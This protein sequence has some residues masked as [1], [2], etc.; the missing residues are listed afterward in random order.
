M[1][2]QFNFLENCEEPKYISLINH[3]DKWLF[4]YYF[5]ITVSTTDNKF[6]LYNYSDNKL[7]FVNHVGTYWIEISIEQSERECYSCGHYP[8]N[9][10]I[11]TFKNN[12]DIQYNEAIGYKDMKGNS[13]VYKYEEIIMEE[14]LED[15]VYYGKCNHIDINKSI[16]LSF[17][18][19]VKNYNFNK[20]NESPSYSDIIKY[21]GLDYRIS[22][23]FNGHLK[24]L[25]PACKSD[26]NFMSIEP[27][28]QKRHEEKI[29]FN[30]FNDSINKLE[31]IKNGK[32]LADSARMEGLIDE[33]KKYMKLTAKSMIEYIKNLTIDNPIILNDDSKKYVGDWMK[34]EDNLISMDLKSDNKLFFLQ[35]RMG[36]GKSIIIDNILDEINKEGINQDTRYILI[37][38]P[39]VSFSLSLVD[40]YKEKVIFDHYKDNN[41]SQNFKFLIIQYESLHKL[42]YLDYKYIIIDEGYQ[43]CNNI[44]NE[45]TSKGSNNDITDKIQNNLQVLLTNCNKV[46]YLDNNVSRF[47]VNLIKKLSHYN[48]A[49]VFYI[50]SNEKK[51]KL[52][53]H[54]TLKS[55]MEEMDEKLKQGKRICLVMNS[56]KDILAI[57][58][59][60]GE[61]NPEV[62]YCDNN[63]EFFS[64]FENINKYFES[65]SH[66]KI[67]AYTN[68]IS[69]GIDINV[70]HVFDYVFVIAKLEY[71][72]A[73]DTLQSCFRVRNPNYNEMHFYAKQKKCSY[74]CL[75][76]DYI[77]SFMRLVYKD[78]LNYDEYKNE[79]IIQSY[80]PT[81]FNNIYNSIG[82]LSYDKITGKLQYNNLSAEFYNKMY[83]IK[84]NTNIY[85][86]YGRFILI[87]M[88]KEMGYDI[89]CKGLL[90]PFDFRR[91]DME[92]I[93]EKTRKEEQVKSENY[94]EHSVNENN[95]ILKNYYDMIEL[96]EHRNVMLYSYNYFN[97]TNET[98]LTKEIY[99]EFINIINKSKILGDNEFYSYVAD[100]QNTNVKSAKKT[101]EDII[102]K[103]KT[104]LQYFDGIETEGVRCMNEF[105]KFV[106][107]NVDKNKFI[108]GNNDVAKDAKKLMSEYK[109]ADKTMK[110]SLNEIAV[111]ARLENDKEVLEKCVKMIC[112]KNNYNTKSNNNQ[113]SIN[114]DAYDIINYY[115]NCMIDNEHM[116]KYEG[117]YVDYNT[118]DEDL[119]DFIR[120]CCVKLCGVPFDKKNRGARLGVYQEGS[121]CLMDINITDPTG[122]LVFTT[123]EKTQKNECIKR[124]ARIAASSSNYQEFQ[125]D[126]HLLM[127]D[128]RI[129]YEEKL[130][131]LKGLNKSAKTDK[132]IKLYQNKLNIHDLHQYDHEFIV[133]IISWVNKEILKKCNF[134]IK[135]EVKDSEG[136]KRKF[137][138]DKSKGD[139]IFRLT[140]PKLGNSI[141][142]VNKN[143]L[144]L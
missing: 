50:K 136:K 29:L 14:D 77:L 7:C 76:E 85:N 82:N 48:K 39:R 65:N 120:Y 135:T 132:L 42:K 90:L 28:D 22:K 25:N 80:T 92:F 75:F 54:D 103:Y 66:I 27:V 78:K 21:N 104:K 89:V 107:E 8:M 83:H 2:Y 13:N 81:Q 96:I 138:H 45:L 105:K 57:K 123:A 144:I 122:L 5:K 35:S 36:S 60:Y 67:F 141:I 32:N 31:Q 62:V 143:K 6:V 101:A 44:S 70:K 40:K 140:K 95:K 34:E 23:E 117:I 88:Y 53:V 56:V 16:P 119:F 99:E 1:D 37:I 71:G 33:Q 131:E 52:I 100:K 108:V 93:F 118:V 3:M 139:L 79:G 129:K 51:G 126:M 84:Y 15:T 43:L 49:N 142:H 74:N 91:D 106:D 115:N 17:D 114:K 112:S 69:V 64:K 110:I 121:E 98:E 4:E 87:H 113:I 47:H 11:R 20:Y 116:I 41:D 97:K 46:I 130:T 61:Y 111:E 72:N 38:T 24:L 125:E 124:V 68:T 18:E 9:Y 59:N 19:Y 12:E 55:I 63:V 73:C 127:N 137:I 58:E 26:D 128:V 102:K 86:S 10:V 109:N 30:Y 94:Y 134:T 133:K